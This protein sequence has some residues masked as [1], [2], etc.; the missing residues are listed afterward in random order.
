[1]ARQSEE[2]KTGALTGSPLYM[3]E[4]LAEHL[5]K[6]LTGDEIRAIRAWFTAEIADRRQATIDEIAKMLPT[7]RREWLE[8]NRTQPKQEEPK[9]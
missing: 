9:T 4:E 8:A 7:A 1:M 6:K 5:A 2:Y 3:S